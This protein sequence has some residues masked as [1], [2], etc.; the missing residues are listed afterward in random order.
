MDWSEQAPRRNHNSEDMTTARALASSNRLKSPPV[1]YVLAYEDG[2]AIGHRNAWEGPDGW[3]PLA[4][5]RQY[6][7]KIVAGSGER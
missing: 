2:R 1:Q 5:C 7:K 3:Q 4:I 6:G